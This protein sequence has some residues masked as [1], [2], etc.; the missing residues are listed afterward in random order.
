MIIIAF[1]IPHFYIYSPSKQKYTTYKKI[2]KFIIKP[3]SKSPYPSPI[4]S[5]IQIFSKKPVFYSREIFKK[6]NNYKLLTGYDKKFMDYV[7]YNNYQAL[8]GEF[9]NKNYPPNSV[10]VYDQ[11]GQTPY[12]AG[13]DKTFI[14]SWGLL[15]RPIGYY[16]FSNNYQKKTSL[17]LYNAFIN[18]IFSI[19][20]S[21]IKRSYTTNEILDYIF[22]QKPDVIIIHQLISKNLPDTLPGKI[23][24]DERFLKNYTPKYI[25]DLW[26]KVYELKKKQTDS[27]KINIPENLYITILN[28]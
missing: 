20:P 26:A 9:I 15:N 10:I 4:F 21:E 14:D 2:I 27:K 7:L 8:V 6:I 12:F 11:M 3:I 24:T 25:L 5:R 23:E 28:D 18:K 19:Y 17:T 22:A 16:V 13:F 1:L